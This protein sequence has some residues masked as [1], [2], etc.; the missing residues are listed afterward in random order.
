MS[1]PRE[2]TRSAAETF[3]AYQLGKGRS[4]CLVLL[5]ILTGSAIYPALHV[6]I[7]NDNSSM[8]SH[9]PQLKQNYNT[10]RKSFGNDELLIIALTAYD[11]LSPEK[12][13]RIHNI[14][15]DL[16]GINGV[17]SVTTP[18]LRQS[19]A[20][21][22]SPFFPVVPPPTTPE[23]GLPMLLS[24][25]RETALI[26]VDLSA[27][28]AKQQLALTTIEA[29]INKVH[30]DLDLR[31][32]GIPLQKLTVS[33]LIQRDQMVTIPLAVVILSLLLV[34]F[35]R[36]LS[37]LLLPLAVMAISLCWTIAL[38]SLGGFALNT[39]TALLPPVVMVLSV[40]T[41][42]HL[43]SS[44]L[45][46]NPL[47]NDKNHHII[48]VVTTLFRPCLFTTLTT[49]MGLASLLLS[50]IPAVRLFGGFAAT[51]ICLSFVVSFL[52]VPI[53]LSF[54][55]QPLGQQNTPSFPLPRIL[56]KLADL[57]IN[58][59]GRVLLVALVSVLFAA[60][61]IPQISNN[62]DLIRFLKADQQLF[63]DTMQI[64]RTFGGVNR[65]EFMLERADG[66]PLTH[67]QDVQQL[68]IFQQ[69]LKTLPQ[70]IGIDSL[71]SLL[72]QQ[73]TAADM[74]FSPDGLDQLTHRWKAA[75]ESKTGIFTRF[76]S[77]DQTR[78]RLSVRTPVLGTADLAA[79]ISNIEKLAD[80]GLGR[81]YQLTPTGEAY[82]LAIDSNQLVRS[83]VSSFSLS[84]VMILTSILL[85]FRS[86]KLLSVALIPNLIPLLWT[87]GL[88]GFLGIDLST[89]TAMIAAVAIGLT[90]DSTIHFL[91]EF[92]RANSG[93]CSAAIRWTTTTTGQAL[94]ISALVLFCGFAAGGASSFL[95]TVYFSLL[96]GTTMLG[97]LI[98]DLVVLPAGLVLMDRYQTERQPC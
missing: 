76:S 97:A 73:T 63:R 70:V 66:L 31:L 54:L 16:T 53:V 43:Y 17:I 34:F 78:L 75:Q 41:S 86:F 56:A 14:R 89:G 19:P 39:I 28:I 29:L 50:N 36:R 65:I 95:P 47:T 44:W 20:A 59:P 98:C 87:F 79:L 83:L 42:V 91:A 94:S 55:P 81:L 5:L 82:Q 11:L 93:N 1:R 22:M 13:R 3:L 35:F 25:D 27:D 40:T 84:L 23:A 67:R 77:S 37:G 60:I 2:G 10:F 96:T 48:K 80:P 46:G 51:G 45:R 62:T 32:T 85:M 68:I 38:Y 21:I 69:G 58:Q 30:A 15:S 92:Q 64:D 9:D 33:R 57:S 8:V 90:V 24:P 4:F 6:D 52:L 18:F 61:G 49:A 12:I 7:E 72:T 74:T 26:L 88:M 71:L